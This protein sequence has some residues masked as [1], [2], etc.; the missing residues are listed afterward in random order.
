MLDNF[1]TLNEVAVI[2]YASME[3]DRS[4]RADEKKANNT[5]NVVSASF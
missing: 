3:T 4:A 1:T 5:M 2:E